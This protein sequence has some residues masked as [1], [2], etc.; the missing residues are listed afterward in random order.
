MVTMNLTDDELEFLID[1]LARLRD[2]KQEAIEASK[3][4]ALPFTAAE[5]G[6]P[7]IDALSARLSVAYNAS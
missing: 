3:A 2:V 4:L 7:K 6:I 1:A 5:F